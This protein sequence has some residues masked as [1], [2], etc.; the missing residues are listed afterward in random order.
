M[1]G[2]VVDGVVVDGVG[3][4]GGG[5]PMEERTLPS[6]SAVKRGVEV[7]VVVEVEVEEGG[8]EVE[9]EGEAEAEAE[10]E[11]G[12]A[13]RRARRRSS[14]A[15]PESA[16]VCESER[17]RPLVVSWSSRRGIPSATATSALRDSMVSD[18]SNSTV[19]SLPSAVETVVE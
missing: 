10:V 18:G 14:W 13:L 17:M 1:D 16:R 11:E 8:F 3:W 2:V 5:A 9:A 15:R 6:M 4:D 19:S 12:R 7:E